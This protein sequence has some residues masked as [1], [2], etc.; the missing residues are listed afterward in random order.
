MSVIIAL[1]SQRGLVWDPVGCRG[2][3]MSESC[4]SWTLLKAIDGD[5][6]DE[7]PKAI[8]FRRECVLRITDT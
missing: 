8:V 2:A 5:I 3:V 7:I 1:S 4:L 6:P